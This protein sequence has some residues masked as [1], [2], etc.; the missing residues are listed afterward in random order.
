MILGYIYLN[1]TMAKPKEKLMAQNLR[2]KG[3]SLKEIADTLK[4]SKNSASNWCKNITLT[5]KQLNRLQEKIIS[6]SYAGRLKG[7]LFQKEK[8][9]RQKERFIKKAQEIGT[10]SKRDLYMI[11]LG[12]YLGEGSKGREFYF[13]NSNPQII[14][15]T[16]QWLEKNFK[17][18]KDRLILRIYINEMHRHR[19]SIVKNFWAHLSG[20]PDHIFMKTVFIK[21]KNKKI[22][23]N[24]DNYFGNLTIKIRRGG[25]LQHHIYG[26]N[27]HIFKSLS[28]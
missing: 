22:Y 15:I 8:R 9:L 14:A 20:I 23:E 2:K 6:G 11:G 26:L 18:T 4:I 5:E 19:E 7:A 17:I 16:L 25:D 10:I 12:L 13:T 27:H 24:Y 1:N 28:V 21:T 3:L